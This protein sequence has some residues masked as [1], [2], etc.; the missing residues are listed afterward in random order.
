MY[1]ELGFILVVLLRFLSKVRKE[2]GPMFVW[3]SVLLKLFR[4]I[5]IENSYSLVSKIHQ[6]IINHDNTLQLAALAAK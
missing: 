3:S 4:E 1:A 5:M 6:M 2:P